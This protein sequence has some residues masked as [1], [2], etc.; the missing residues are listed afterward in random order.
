M[1]SHT[2]STDLFRRGRAVL[3]DGVSSP[4]RSFS[5]VGGTPICA[6]S[7]KGATI[8][9][10]DGNVYIDF[11]NAFGALILGHAREEVVEAVA[12]QASMGMVYGLSTALEYELAEK[13]VASTPSIEKIRFVCSGT[14]AVMTAARIARSHTGR[15]LLLKFGG[16]YHGHSDALLASPS[17]LGANG[18]R[19]KGSTQGIAESLN[20]E[21]LL[22]E[23]NDEEQL[24]ALFSAHGDRIAAVLVEPF[25]TNMGFVKPQPGFHRL[26]RELCDRHGALFIFDEVVTGFR[27]HFGGVCNSLGIDPDLVTFG[28]IIGGGAPIGAYAGKT[29][30]MQHVAVGKKV[31]QSGTFAAN[32]LTMAAGNAALDVLS[33]PGFYGE[34]EEKGAWLEAAITSQ[35]AA[36]RIPY[37][38][39]RHGALAGVAFRDSREPMKSYRDVKTQ[40]YEVFK[41]VHARMLERGFLMPPS[42]E[43]PIFISAAHS[44]D[45][46]TSFADALA[47]SIQLFTTGRT[48]LGGRPATL[49]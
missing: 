2:K 43:E 13:I 41:K 36:R 10:V 48:A 34:L 14:E 27:F 44:R 49:S 3:P 12:R 30:F 15:S 5:Q 28:K 37:H 47:E 39:S 22:C 23:Y 26:I 42:L 19:T 21:V 29:Q 38:V 17:N 31:F 18:A 40:D 4:M 7:A 16:A 45:D 8:T 24:A 32:P 33:R 25:A 1:K 35:F 11:L 46:L 9:D 6:A 20:R